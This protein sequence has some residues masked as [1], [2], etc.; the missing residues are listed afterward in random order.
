MPTETETGIDPKAD[1]QREIAAMAE[2]R[3]GQI[4]RHYKGGLYSIVSVSVSEM[5]LEVLVTYT[6]NIKGGDT[7]RTLADFTEDVTVRMGALGPIIY[8]RFKRVEG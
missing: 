8:P 3:R 1:A 5:T 7:T 6:S 2:P 4:Y